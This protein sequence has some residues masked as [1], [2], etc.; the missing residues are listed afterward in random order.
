MDEQLRR[1]PIGVLEV[2][3]GG[4]VV[5]AN[6]IAQELLPVDEDPRERQIE[7][8]YPRSV[9][10][11]LLRMFEQPGEEAA[12]FEEYY[13]DLD[14]WFSVS[15]VPM[16]ERATV[17]VRDVTTRRR[18]EQTVD[19]LR[20]ERERV[21]AIYGL[22][23]DILPELI[24]ASSREEITEALCTQLGEAD[25]YRFVW[26]GE[27]PVGGEN[28]TV[29]TV[30][31]EPGDTFPAVREALADAEPTPEERALE[32]EQLQVVSS[33]ADDPTVA[34]AV[35]MAGFADGVQ[36]GL[37]LPLVYG[38]SVYGVVGVYTTEA[39]AFSEYERASFKA[40]GELA[41][42]AI[43]ATRNRRLLLSDTITEVTFDVGNDAVLAALSA[44]CDATLELKGVVPRGDDALIC[45]VSVSGADSHTVADTAGE[46]ADVSDVRVIRESD[47]GGSIEMT[48]RGEGPLVEVASLGATIQ[49]ATFADG[50]GRLVAELP[51]DG[52]V[53]RM[54]NAVG[55]SNSVDIVA[56]HD[57]QRSV[58]TTRE[59]N[60]ELATRLTDRQA[61][62]LKTAYLADYFESP[63]GSTAEEVA[64]S[65]DITGSTLL[66][67]LR[68]SQ[69]KLLD[70][71]YDDHEKTVE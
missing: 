51:S 20:S 37:A 44:T 61:T 45:F 2:T 58:T 56:K 50:S 22:I 52:N 64:N 62:V 47:T 38:S 36:S 55:S 23:S 41:G 9:E 24:K 28:L 68:T 5:D 70:A 34:E 39:N 65:L 54:A 33:L 26:V 7:D 13:P 57:K 42:F 35:R 71:F 31:G 12:E 6:G 67:H 17:Y 1:A 40:L 19:Q 18:H 27:Q 48:I 53:R 14:R 66:Y 8:V 11:S 29:N 4:T 10:D 3:T 32:H 21:S 69:R 30:A 16:D 43:S 25:R 49:A 46:R 15:V 60:D 59:F 63:R